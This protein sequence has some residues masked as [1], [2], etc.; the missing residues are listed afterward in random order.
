MLYTPTAAAGPE[1]PWEG[2]Q[3]GPVISFDLIPVSAANLPDGRI[4]FFSGS[5]RLTWPTTEQTYSAIFDPQSESVVDVFH[6]GHNMFCA[7]LA[8]LAD[9][10]VFVNG[11][12]NQQNSPWTSLFDYRTD[13]WT[14]IE[15]MASGGRWYPTTVA[16]PNGDVF[17]AIGTATNQTNPDVWNESTGWEIKN[18][19]NFQDMV[20]SPYSGSHGEAAW[21]PLLHVA[22]NGKIFHSGPT[23]RWHYIDPEGGVSGNG[24]YEQTGGLFSDWY[25]KHGTTVMYGEGKL[26]TAGGWV[27]GGN[28]ASTNRAIT[29]DI[30]GPTPVVTEVAPM[31]HARKFHNGVPLPTG[32]ILV[33][34]GNTSGAKFSDAGAILPAEMWD[35]TTGTWQLLSAMS[36]ARNYHSVALMLPDGRVFAGG[37]G[38]CSGSAFCNGSSH[39]DGQIYSPAYL[40]NNDGSLAARP[41]ITLAPAHVNSGDVFRVEATP[42]LQRFTLIKMGATT[43]GLNT[44]TRFLEVSFSETAPGSGEYDLL[45]N[46]NPNV[47]TSGYWMLFGVDSNGVPSVAHT[48]QANAGGTPQLPPV[49]ATIPDQTTG[50]GSTVSYQVIASD[51]DGDPIEYAATGL[52]AGLSINSSTGLITGVVSVEAI[53]NVTVTATDNI[54]GTDS[55]GF[56]WEVTQGAVAPEDAIVDSGT[57]LDVGSNWTTVTLANT[58]ADMVVVATPAYDESSP[59]VVTRVRNAAGNSFDIR[60]QNPS[61]SALSGYTVHYMA[62][63]VGVYNN[64]VQ[65][66]EAVKYD[67]AVT[68]F[69]NSWNGELRSYQQ[70]Y[71]SP[72]VLG[73]VM[74]ENDSRWSVFWASNSSG[75]FS[76]PSW[77]GLR[78]GKHVGEDPDTNRATETIGYVVFDAGTGMVGDFAFEAGLSANVVEGVV[79]AAAPW[80]VP[81]S[82]QFDSALLASAGIKGSNG[83]WPLLYG[84]APIGAASVSIAGDE[85][86]VGDQER[87]RRREEMAVVALAGDVDVDLTVDDIIP[88]PVVVG[89]T[90]TFTANASREDL[91]Y[92]YSFGDG[93]TRAPSTDPTASHTY[94]A[95]GRYVVIVTVTDPV[96]GEE[97]TEDFVQLIHYPLTANKPTSASGIVVHSTYDQVWSV[98]PDNDTIAVVDSG[99]NALI[100]EIA[101]GNQPV[102][103]AVASNGDVW[104]SNRSSAT[105]SIVDPVSLTVAATINLPFASQPYGITVHPTLDRAYVVLEATGEVVMYNTATQAVAGN[106][107]FLGRNIRY[108]SIGGDGSPLLVSRFITPPL[109]NEDTQAPIVESGGVQ[110]GGEVLVLDATTL[111][112]QDTVVL[113]HSDRLASEHTG[114]GVPNYLGPAV[115]SPDAMSARVGSKQ[116]NILAGALRGGDGMTFD[117]TVR[118]ITS[119]VDIVSLTEQFVARID[120]DNASV[121]RHTVFDNYGG[122]VFSSLEGNREIA[123]SDAYTSV[124]LYRFD[125]GRAPQSIALSDDGATLYVHNF[126][127]RTLGVYD[128]SDITGLNELNAFEVATVSTVGQE[129]LPPNVLTGKQLFYDARDTRLTL[130]SYMSCAA[131]HNDGAQDGRIWDMTGMG[132]GLR[133]TIELNGRGGMA[134]GLLHWSANFDEVQDFEGQIR[135]LSGGTGL[136]SDADFFAGTRSEPLGDTKAGLSADLDALA[137]YVTSLGGFTPSPHRNA[138][139]T[140]TPDG[141]EGL[142]LFERENCAQCHTLIDYTDSDTTPNLHDIGTLKPASGSRLGGSLDGIDTP[143]LVSVWNTGPYLHDGS[144]ADVT[145]AVSAHTNVGLSLTSDELNKLGAYLEQIDGVTRSISNNVVPVPVQFGAVT[146]SQLSSNEWHTVTF[147]QPFSTVPVVVAGPPSF[148]DTDPANVRLRNVTS[149][150]FEF[151]IDEWEYLDGVHGSELVSWLAAE[152]GVHDLN[153]VLLEAGVREGVY[154]NF[155]GTQSLT[156]GFTDA[157]V[158]L[159]Q[160]VTINEPTA[161]TLRIKS[162]TDSSFRVKIYEEQAQDGV[163]VDETAHYIALSTGAGT[164]NGQA[165]A[166]GKTGDTVTDAWST[167]GFGTGYANPV[168]FGGFQDNQGRDVIVLRHRNLTAS[169]VE[170]F[171]EE[172]TSADAE[173]GHVTNPVGWVVVSGP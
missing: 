117:Q 56:Q 172:E 86:Q 7:H 83:G 111:A 80:D 138:D 32:E 50:I 150:G 152:P 6:P 164:I 30:N 157:P 140:L 72:I 115:V 101:V 14:Q 100:A 33:I 40:F 31:H 110:Y 5:E 26:L 55:V 114:P 106:S 45:A 63:E 41:D 9:G 8:M 38:Y 109:P 113:Q 81:L 68:D 69:K 120:H 163:H 93:A 43:H 119:K 99:T 76:A 154:H 171:A 91:L 90:A 96:T 156:A 107:G 126:M 108:A 131:C 11:G 66:V 134:H 20:T 23:P 44:D 103:A 36:V 59:P 116:D 49:L 168:F 46:A 123:V 22:P 57:L 153:G 125:V 159:T 133:N 112:L 167:I 165:F 166:V 139:G 137:A 149:S 144:A 82:D 62:I 92:S 24:D 71:I 42:S 98:N 94:S 16:L 122:Y 2:G 143:T 58:Y 54:H 52:P 142:L 37:G 34:G 170:V 130:D 35:P 84:S 73:Q 129:S 79:E 47:L 60:V 67:S 88:T 102:S 74:T 17:T 53:S 21:W 136:M 135:S 15:N 61:G 70:S 97:A 121:A 95:P 104:V 169:Q 155:G 3:W 124:E 85:D 10:R 4:V 75:A 161:A 118:A 173:T 13:T 146:V 28:P 162:V 145:E 151:Q 148:Y 160:L 132:E 19:I 105:L 48:L 27:S 29:I 141:E 89:G 158:V 1:D 39:P 65:K 147:D 128:V 51:P 127:D 87:G 64:G 12:R 78:T 18:G 77:V 25:S